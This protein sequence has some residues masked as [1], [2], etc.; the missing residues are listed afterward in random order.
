MDD[1]Q[2]AARIRARLRELDISPIT[3]ALK[4]GLERNYIR[5]FLIDKKKSIKT[6]HYQQVATGLDWSVEQLLGQKQF[7]GVHRNRRRSSEPMSDVQ[8]VPEVD[9]RA[10]ASY[11]GGTTPTDFV[12]GEDGQPVNNEAVRSTWGI[13]LPFLRDELRVRPGRVHILPVRGDSM[14][15]ALFDGDRAIIDLDDTDASQGGIFALLDDHGSVIIKQVEMVRGAESGRIRCK[16]R[17]PH[18]EPFDLILTETVRIIGR[19]ACKIT[20]L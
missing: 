7:G 14:N 9:V 2:L 6:K 3:A 20:R 19:V 5:D 1:S 15:D 17:N 11:A 4:G 8:L 12:T 16:S 18:Y 10:G 13:P